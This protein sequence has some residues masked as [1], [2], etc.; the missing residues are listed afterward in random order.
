[1]DYKVSKKAKDIIQKYIAGAFKDVSLDFYGI[2]TPK[3]KELINVE[4]PI[5]DIND[6]S[7]D[8]IFLLEDNTY[9]HLE[10]QTVYNKDDLIRFWSYD[11]RLYLRDKRKIHTVIVY[12][13]S[14]KD[15]EALNI[16]TST[17]NPD[18]IMLKDYNGDSIY[19]DI[20]NK[21]L[22]GQDITDLDILNLLFLPL[23]KNKKRKKTVAID[24]V[25]LAKNIK[26]KNKRNICI[27]SIFAFTYKYLEYNEIN[28][29]LEVIK[30]TDL[31]TLLMEQAEHEKAIEIAKNALKEGA[32][33]AFVQKITKLDF[34]VIEKLKEEISK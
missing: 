5:I 2:N 17:F 29:I 8:F 1:M 4:L 23:M 10:F 19:K 33:V 25:K 30:M 27:G 13:S 22:K 21:V 9:L 26:D 28:S 3:I 15:I 16:G 24:S 7:T 34:N 6:N 14:V 31:G 20:E 18:I 11:L 12:A 32:S